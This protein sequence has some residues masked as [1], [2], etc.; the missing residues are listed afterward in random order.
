M[1]EAVDIRALKPR[2]LKPKTPM[3]E[4]TMT[5]VH[6][7]PLLSRGGP[8]VAG[9]RRGSA[10]VAVGAAGE[11]AGVAVAG[12]GVAV[13]AAG[14]PG[15]PRM[16]TLLVSIVTSPFRARALPDTLAPFCRAML[17]SARMF[18]TN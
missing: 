3:T 7:K 14:A 2:A 1:A 18:P 13:A 16:V 5:R 11:E 17:V 4:A 12:A 9:G 6:E 8:P 15:Q 10:G